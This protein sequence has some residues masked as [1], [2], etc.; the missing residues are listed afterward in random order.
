MPQTKASLL[1]TLARFTFRD[2]SVHLL[3]QGLGG[4]PFHGRIVLLV[5]EW[6]NSAAEMVANFASENHL[7]IIVGTRTA[8][9]VLGAVNFHVGSGYWLRLPIFGWYT[10]RG[11]CLEG[12][13]VSADAVVEPDPY[14]LNSGVDH[15]L[16][17]AMEA[18]GGIGAN[19]VARQ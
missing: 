13:G 9:N 4:Q 19:Q 7:A 17:I 3:T 10:S 14:L 5:N 16:N 12:K 11:Q 1:F 18:F 2:K 15:Q 8:G 6:T